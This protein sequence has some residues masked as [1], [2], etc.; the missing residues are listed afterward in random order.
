MALPK[1][2]GR[3]KITGEV[4]RGGMGAVLRAK[5]PHL[6][7]EVAIK[8]IAPR[9]GETADQELT[10]RFL[11]EA[12][13][14]ARINHPGVVTV[15]DA[16]QDDGTLYLVMEMVEGESLGQ[17]L[18]SGRYPS[19]R[20]A[21]RFAAE[22]A[23]ALQAAHSL[24]VVHRDIK[25]SNILITHDGRIKVTDFGVAK[26][27]GDDTGLTRTGGTVGS[28]AYMAPEQVMGK[29][30]DGRADL[31]SLGVVLYQMLLKRKPFPADTITTLVYQ[32]LNHDP[33][34]EEAIQQTLGPQTAAFLG[35]CLAKDPAQRPADA[36]TFAEQARTLM[37]GDALDVGGTVPTM[38]VAGARVADQSATVTARPQTGATRVDP[39][40]QAVPRPAA[41]P[42]TAAT[43][44]E[45]R[46]PPG[47]ATVPETTSAAGPP[48]S[49]RYPILWLL[50]GAAVGVWVVVGA[51]YL[52]RRQ[53][54][55]PPP[56]ANAAGAGQVAVAGPTE[57]VAE[58]PPAAA[59][60]E[61]T[62][63]PAAVRQPTATV[64]VETR[65]TATVQTAPPT[66]AQWAPPRPT[67]SPRPAFVPPPTQ[68][69]QAPTPR[70]V[71]TRPAEQRPTPA[72][73]W[74][75]GATATPTAQAPLAEPAATPVPP[76]PR[77]TPTPPIVDTF[78]CREKAEF[79]IDPEDAMVAIDGKEI[80]IADDYDGFGD[81]GEYEF[82]GP[83]TYYASFTFEG[84][85]KTWVKIVVSD[86][87]KKKTVEI[88]TE[89][90]K[91]KKKKKKDDDEDDDEDDDD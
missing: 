40:A 7:R 35:E 4:G 78:E 10:Q 47:E 51:L 19:R 65:P 49:A 50:G 9:V 91:D 69:P 2:V 5:D 15:H 30:L 41:T 21:L 44:V 61:P 66:P 25:P 46:S 33:F 82:P 1:Q 64:A 36:A 57:P 14:A 74:S 54:A 32:I 55:E 67:A 63:V 87:A 43:E 59:S 26:A 8:V 71:A 11:R 70:P 22:A 17:R 58:I 89:M 62:A 90:K 13:L 28:P 60:E 16:G 37:Q 76:T 79:D 84:Y 88:D 80:G 48:R 34:S 86:D 20:E 29:D 31:F 24:G 52:M 23:E 73:V 77:P 27:I 68:V 75:T 38:A 45:L 39:V 3:Y 18:A 6:E 56:S 72:F 12:K 42:A 53:P 85:Q 81:P 83:G